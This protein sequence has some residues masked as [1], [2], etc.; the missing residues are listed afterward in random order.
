ML[1]TSTGAS[2]AFWRGDNNRSGKT[3]NISAS[4]PGIGLGGVML[5]IPASDAQPVGPC[6]ADSDST[7]LTQV[8]GVALLIPWRQHSTHAATLKPY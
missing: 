3:D 2:F 1:N 5:A 4:D 6:N 7:P 8:V